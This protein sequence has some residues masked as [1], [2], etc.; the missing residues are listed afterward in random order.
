MYMRTVN[1]YNKTCNSKK[2]WIFLREFGVGSCLRISLFFLMNRSNVSTGLYFYCTWNKFLNSCC[3]D[4]L[5]ARN[6]RSLHKNKIILCICSLGEPFICV[7]RMLASARMQTMFVLTIKLQFFTVAISII[8]RSLFSTV[9]VVVLQY[10][11][12][13][14]I[15]M[16]VL[17]WFH[18][19]LLFHYTRTFPNF[20][21]SF[22]KLYKFCVF[23]LFVIVIYCKNRKLV[24]W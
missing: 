22:L 12:H 2:S 24:L 3:S 1:D 4:Y 10:I 18:Q 5:L 16:K 21:I 6:I 9:S 20:A 13:C 23:F 17:F 8:F 11:F 19:S 15:N 14:L 7:I